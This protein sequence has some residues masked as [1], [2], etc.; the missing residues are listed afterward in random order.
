MP[1]K[2]GNMTNSLYE[3]GLVLFTHRLDHG[4][5]LIAISCIDAYLDQFM[6]VECHIDFMLDVRGQTIASD[7]DNRV[8]RVSKAAQ[9]A[10]LL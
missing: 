2:N 8:K 4:V 7:N 1:V 6:L 9:F 3:F 5:A 10:Y